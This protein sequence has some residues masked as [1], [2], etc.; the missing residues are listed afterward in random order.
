MLQSCFIFI[1]FTD[2][3][4]CW[5]IALWVWL[6]PV[7][8]LGPK[9]K[10]RQWSL[11]S[12]YLFIV[13]IWG[14]SSSCTW[15]KVNLECVRA[16]KFSMASKRAH[17]EPNKFK[18]CLRVHW[19]DMGLCIGALWSNR[20][21]ERWSAEFLSFLFQHKMHIGREAFCL[22]CLAHTHSW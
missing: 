5:M 1:G 13:T 4:F 20:G 11:P 21:W 14:V 15:A 10:F 9:Q 18:I 22:F 6:L 8:F 17:I 16:L 3:Q 12:P 19:H 7:A 2:K